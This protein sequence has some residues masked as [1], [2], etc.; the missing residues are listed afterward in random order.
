VELVDSIPPEPESFEIFN[1]FS[2]SVVSPVIIGETTV[3]LD[4]RDNVLRGAESN[5]GNLV[6]DAMRDAFPQ[7]DFAL[8]P[9]GS[10]WGDKIIPTGVIRDIDILES[11]PFDENL[12]LL[13]MRGDSLKAMLERSVSAISKLYG[14]FFQIA[15]FSIEIDS[16][17][18]PFGNGNPCE[19]NV[20]KGSRVKNISPKKGDWKK[21]KIYKIV[22]TDFVANGG[23]CFPIAAK[24]ADVRVKKLSQ[25]VI[26]YIKKSPV[27]PQFEG[28]IKVSP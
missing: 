3:E 7:A 8:L 20:E 9:S 27:S 1:T 11:L 6:A 10:V 17:K 28:R 22:T 18:T 26:N 12:V 25:T 15:G 13:E 21:D 19:G 2:D 4:A 16:S 23:Y 24:S 14:G 5:F